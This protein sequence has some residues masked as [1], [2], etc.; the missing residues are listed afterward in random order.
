MLASTAPGKQAALASPD[1]MHALV[2]QP[3]GTLMVLDRSR[4]GAQTIFRPASNCSAPFE[5]ALLPNG[6]LVLRERNGLVL[7]SSTSACTGNSLCY[8]YALQDSGSLV[9]TDADRR[10]VWDSSSDRGSSSVAQGWLHQLVGGST[11]PCINSGPL[12]PATRLVS[13]SGRYTLLISQ[14][15]AALQLL[16]SS[17]GAQVWA[18]SGSLPGKAPARLCLQQQQGA[19]VLSAD[20]TQLWRS[21]SSS[22]APSPSAGPFVA[23]V[24]GAG[25]LELLDGS[26]RRRDVEPKSS[27]TS[28]LGKASPP[29]GKASL[30]PSLRPA[31]RQA[32]PPAARASRRA[33]AAGAPAPARKPPA[34]VV[35]RAR[36][37]A[38]PLS[39]K[40]PPKSRPPPK[41]GV[42][43]AIVALPGSHVRPP[44]PAP[45]ARCRL[46]EDT[47]CG[48]RALCGADAACRQLGCCDGQLV[49]RRSNEWLW[50]CSR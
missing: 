12:F 28:A 49:C 40:S 30:R 42:S 15:G 48:G 8:S 5:L 31:L 13:R 38:R 2:L 50:L 22:Q 41:D 29:P 14:Q 16:D 20:G 24:T 23:E 36:P 34:V 3:N 21:G 33:P 19:L 45:L 4:G 27:G 43:A 35:P 32:S 37:P 18:P 9:V 17:T 39:T 44:P 25:R 1:E 10:P 11:Q 7:W 47:P 46:Q 6:L 26:C